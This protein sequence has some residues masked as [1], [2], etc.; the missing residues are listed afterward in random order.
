ML[1]EHL[2]TSHNGEKEHGHDVGNAVAH[3]DTG[4]LMLHQASTKALSLR[5]ARS[6]NS[7][8]GNWLETHSKISLPDH[9]RREAAQEVGMALADTL[10]HCQGHGFGRSAGDLAS[11]GLPYVVMLGGVIVLGD[12]TALRNEHGTFDSA[13]PCGK[14]HA[15]R[16]GVSL[17]DRW[18]GKARTEARPVTCRVACD[19]QH[20][21][22]GLSGKISPAVEPCPDAF[23]ACIVG[24]GSESKIAEYPI[25]FG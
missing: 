20:V 17:P 24:C 13:G 3:R 22:E 10:E 21:V 8:I 11:P 14:V 5:P 16:E 18:N 1:D 15:I 9:K 12:G 19:R 4:N 6:A 25:Q 23:F 7:Y 2:A